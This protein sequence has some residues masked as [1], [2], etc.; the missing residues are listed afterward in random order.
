MQ[1][2]VK[3]Y[4]SQVLNA[5]PDIRVIEEAV[6]TCNVVMFALDGIKA[7]KQVYT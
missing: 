4:A 1:G 6:R 3:R 2:V 5:E 7:R